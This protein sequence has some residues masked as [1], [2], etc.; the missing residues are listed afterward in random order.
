MSLIGLILFA[1]VVIALLV[2][3]VG[4]LSPP[5]DGGIVRI[6]QAVI[7]IGGAL[8]IAHRAGLF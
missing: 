1:L 8:F 5:L 4:Y 3:G 6:I 2:Y 7:I